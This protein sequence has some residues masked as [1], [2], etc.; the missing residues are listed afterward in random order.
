[1][2]AVWRRHSRRTWQVR[3]GPYTGAHAVDQETER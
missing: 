3:R 1:M 2:S